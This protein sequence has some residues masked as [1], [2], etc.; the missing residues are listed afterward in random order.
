MLT[1]DL[2]ENDLIKTKKRFVPKRRA[3]HLIQTQSSGMSKERSD[4]NEKENQVPSKKKEYLDSKDSTKSPTGSDKCS[5]RSRRSHLG[6]GPR[7]DNLAKNNINCHE[8]VSKLC[9]I[10]KKIA[11]FL[12]K[13]CINR[14]DTSSGPITSEALRVVSNSTHKTTKKILSRMIE[15]KLLSRLPGKKGKGGYVVFELSQEFIDVVRLQSQLE[16]ENN[17]SPIIN[18]V[19]NPSRDLPSKWKE[20]DFSPLESVG[21]GAPQIKQLYEKSLNSPE[22]IQESIK[23]FSFALENNSK[24]KKFAEEGKALTVIMGVLRKGG[25][26][27][28]ANYEA[29]KDKALREI[30]QQK[31]AAKEKRN[32]LIGEL[33]N[34]EFEEWVKSLSSSEVD[35][36]V[37]ED[38]RRLKAAKTAALSQYFKE[39]V[40]VPRLEKEGLL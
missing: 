30:V 9:G 19:T 28:E 32:K 25:N 38:R 39:K 12:V 16:Y 33:V 34:L 13:K 27:F 26:W 22:V 2:S 17:D 18:Q 11:C 20:V 24:V 7:D 23:H 15:K 4:N 6:N 29:P 21:F 8:E 37:P 36:I 35:E 5:S 40:L 10:Q 31:K 3:P 1:T 14:K